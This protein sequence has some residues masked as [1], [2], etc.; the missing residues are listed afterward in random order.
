MAELSDYTYDGDTWY[1]TDRTC[2][3][4]RNDV[5][6]NGR[7]HQC[8]DWNAE[9]EDTSSCSWWEVIDE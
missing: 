3:D 1:P 6:S 2:P 9:G 7:I 8:H 4:C 5:W